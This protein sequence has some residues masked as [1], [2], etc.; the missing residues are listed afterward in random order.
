M[1]LQYCVIQVCYA[2]FT[3]LQYCVT[4]F[5]LDFDYTVHRTFGVDQEKETVLLVEDNA[6]NDGKEYE[7]SI[8]EPHSDSL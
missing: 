6:T 8:Q 5:W 4:H 2:T 3:K 1:N 7:T